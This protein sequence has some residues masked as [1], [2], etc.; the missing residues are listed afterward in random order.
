MTATRER[1]GA[2]VPGPPPGSA[3]ALVRAAARVS[4]TAEILLVGTGGLVRLTDSGL[5]CPTWPRCGTQLTTTPELG[6]HGVIE[7]GNRLL[8]VALVLIALA[9][10]V[11]AVRT[12]RQRRDLTL[13]AVLQLLSIPAQAVLGGITVL[14]HLNPWVVGA[15]FVFSMVLVVLMT[16]FVVRARSAPGLRRLV[17]PP[18]FAAATALMAVLVAVTVGL[19]VVTTGSGPHAGAQ[20]ADHGRNGLD[21]VVLQELH[22]YPAYALVLVSIVLL[23][24]ALRLGL[25]RRVV[26]A[27]VA[28]EVAQIVI[29]IVQARNGLPPYLVGIHELL[30]ACLVAAASAVTFTLRRPVVISR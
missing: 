5:G 19:G 17:V 24:A 23:V 9:A 3:P 10:V 4:L 14:T 28:V 11:V 15:H 8:T 25:T 6:I 13:L 18:W 29:G 26:I 16:A 2:V 12:W 1:P 7:F 21:P 22:S 27:L 20:S 30:S